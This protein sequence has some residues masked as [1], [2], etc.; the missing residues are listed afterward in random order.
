MIASIRLR[1]PVVG[2]FLLVLCAAAAAPQVEIELVVQ[3]QAPLT[4]G[5]EWMRVFSELKPGG[6][7]IRQQ[8]LAQP[9]IEEVKTGQSTVYRVTGLVTSQNELHLPGAKFSLQDKAK[10][11]EWLA[12]VSRGEG[13]GPE[14]TSAT[15]FGL[16]PEQLVRVRDLL[17]PQVSEPTAG[18]PA[19]QVIEQIAGGLTLPIRLSPAART[20]LQTG[21][22]RDEL[23]GLSS[24]TALAAL[25]RPMGLV[26]VPS[27][28]RG[29][30]VNL[31]IAD[32]RSA[33]ESWP[34][35]WP[36][37]K[38]PR[39]TLPKL[40]DFLTIEIVD[41]PVSEVLAALQPRL[42]APILLDHN[43]LVRQDIVISQVRVD[44]PS[45]RT[46]Y[47]N[48]LDRTLFKA[49]LQF[50]VRLDERDQ[51]LLWVSPIKR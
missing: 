27:V 49:R 35:G 41:R 21:K 13:G 7:R 15:A 34:I 5:H 14:K 10:L 48:V 20:A 39:D 33:S 17:R 28:T 42:G 3:R 44:I 36:A 2:F 18:K 30:D 23:S 24:G 12:K 38:K 6:I 26:M 1:G 45:K 25:L 32:V 50:E 46:F 9:K 47:K 29:S 11:R 37:E 19:F 8:G 43:S 31:V 51:P 40:F 22:A 16:T 4:A